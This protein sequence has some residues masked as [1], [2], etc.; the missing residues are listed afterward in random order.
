[1]MKVFEAETEAYWSTRSVET[2]VRRDLEEDRAV[3][4]SMKEGNSMDEKWLMLCH[5]MIRMISASQS[6]KRSQKQQ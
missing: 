5:R 1:M 4:G 2:Y 3:I 6:L